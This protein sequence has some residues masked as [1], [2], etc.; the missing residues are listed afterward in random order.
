MLSV[1]VYCAAVC[2]LRES[3]RNSIF[4]EVILAEDIKACTEYLDRVAMQNLIARRGCDI[5]RGLIAQRDLVA[6]ELW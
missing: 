4:E 3:E 2:L 1:S 5:L 6:T